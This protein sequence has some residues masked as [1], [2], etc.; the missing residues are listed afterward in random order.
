MD[1]R[2][3]IR[4]G[5]DAAVWVSSGRWG[6]KRITDAQCWAVLRAE[7][8]YT[9][10]LR[11]DVARARPGAHGWLNW[12][13]A[14]RE[15]LRIAWELRPNSVWRFGRVFLTCPRC[16]HRATRIYVPRKDVGG[17][18]RRCWGLTYESRQRRTYRAGSLA[19]YGG[20]FSALSY[21]MCRS[22]VAREERVDGAAKRRAERQAILCGRGRHRPPVN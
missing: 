5:L 22:A 12:Q 2:R 8:V 21:A 4:P 15:P 6:P 19:R 11:D 1:R 7:D 16:R 3:Y 18:C 9:G 20:L 10:L 14:D 13:L 17:A